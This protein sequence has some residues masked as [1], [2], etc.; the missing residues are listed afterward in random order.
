[1]ILARRKVL[2]LG[3]CLFAALALPAYARA[4]D[5]IFDI[6]MAGS[7]NG[8]R[9]WFTPVGVLIR[10]GQTVRWTNRDTTNAHT[11][12]AYHPDNYHRERRMPRAAPAWD[13]GYL[14]P[15]DSFTVVFT[16][17]GIYDYYCLPHEMAGMVGRI[18]VGMPS[19]AGG[20]WNPDQQSDMPDAAFNALP[21]VTD[22]LNRGAVE[23]RVTD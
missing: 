5:G 3:G 21:N 14:L 6:E 8:G 4:A 10:P 9:V 15:G 2:Q 12:T 22:I 17:P 23:R 11:A 18:V 19:L 13:S 7:A 16:V 20:D 1:M